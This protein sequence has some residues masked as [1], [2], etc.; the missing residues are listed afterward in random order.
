MAQH[1]LEFLNQ[2]GTP[3]SLQRET[4][5]VNITLARAA[6]I[7]VVKQESHAEHYANASIRG[8]TFLR[9]TWTFRFDLTSR[10]S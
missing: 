2:I 10:I 3:K 1:P 5:D 6:V 7:Q 4:P 9:G 8:E